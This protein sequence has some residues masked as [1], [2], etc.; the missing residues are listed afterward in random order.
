MKAAFV[1]VCLAVLGGVFWYVTAPR[2]ADHLLISDAVARPVGEGAAVSLMSIANTGA[3]DR[4]IA[5]SSS[6]ADAMLVAP[7]GAEG[8][9]VPTGKSA[10]A[11][12]GAHIMLRNAGEVLGEGAL[13][14]L[15]L[16]FEKAGDVAVKARLAEPAQTGHAAHV[17]LLGMGDIHVIGEG[18]MVPQISLSVTQEGPGWRVTLQTR[19]F[20]FDEANMGKDHAPGTGHGHIYVGGMKLGRLFE[21]TFLIGALPAG[22]HVVRV[23]LNTNDHRAYVADDRPISAEAVIL[24]D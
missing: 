5:V 17:G 6:Q 22:E 21:P 19:H 11:L 3:P 8:V 2:P 13:I 9:P 20:A 12:D 10:L 4:L 14:A 15:T 24:V 23:T 7:E 18:E 16:Q 1:L